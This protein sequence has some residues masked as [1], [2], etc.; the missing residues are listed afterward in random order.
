MTE[1]RTPKAA[2]PRDSFWPLPRQRFSAFMLL[3]A[4]MT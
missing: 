3:N 4:M 2:S 1:A